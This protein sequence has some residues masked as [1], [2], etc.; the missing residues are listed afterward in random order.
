MNNLR[1]V[2]AKS[3]REWCHLAM[4][5]VQITRKLYLNMYVA[6]SDNIY[7]RES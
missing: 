2:D 6:Y 1:S 4:A 3:G 7:G 5:T